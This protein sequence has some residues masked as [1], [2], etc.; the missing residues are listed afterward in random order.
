MNNKKNKGMPWYLRFFLKLITVSI[1]VFGLGFIFN[2]AY[3]GTYNITQAQ[4]QKQNTTN[5]REA[6]IKVEKGA[7]TEDIAKAI[8][9]EGLISNILWFRVQSRLLK[10]DGQY[11]AGTFSLNTTMDDQTIME[12]LTAQKMVESEAVRVTIPEG[13]NIMQI[14]A[15]LEEAELVSKEAFLRA[16]NDRD[17]DYPFLEELPQGRK[18]KLEGYLFPDTYLFSPDASA[19]AIVI[20][21]L[22]R[23]QEITDQYKQELVGSP[24]SFDQIITIAS[25]IE[26]EAKLDEERPMISGVIYNRIEDD[27]KLQMCST[28][29]YALEKRTANLSY[30]DLKVESPYNT[31]KYPGLPAGAI[32]SPGEASI[33]AA[34]L[35]EENDYYFFVLK[36][37]GDGSHSFNK[38][39]QEHNTSKAKYKQSIDKNFHQ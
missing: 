2:T 30:D 38:T 10:Y 15:R 12:T 23:F 14:A 8:H 37:L 4:A 1:F 36:D 25:I 39:A 29:Q 31:Y 16:V 13:F 33:R 21:M 17:Y 9:K 34:F 6:E 5:V 26:Q 7:S 35:P 32:C 19:E 20:K 24:Y 28:V 11:Q 22:N 18:N 27:M 3:Q